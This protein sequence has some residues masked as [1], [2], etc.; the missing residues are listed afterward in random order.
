V[1]VDLHV[2]TWYSPD[3]MM[4]PRRLLKKAVA[5]GLSAVAITDHNRLTEVKGGEIP[6]IPGEEIKTSAGEIIGLF[7]NQEIPAGLDPYEAMD[8]VREQGGIVVI[9]HPF[10]KF[11]K[12][13]ALLLHIRDVPRDVLIEVKNGRYVCRCFEKRAEE[14]ARKRGLPTVGGSD[15]HTYP[16]L[17]RVWT[18]VP[19]FSDSEE[20]F[21]ILRRGETRPAGEPFPWMHATVPALKFLHFV[22]VLPQRP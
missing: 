11:R 3:G 2:H 20:L 12:R 6:I 15:A 17:G 4:E 21:K 18:E 5:L 9:P 1:R 22:G 7:L 13:T 14:F 8:R 10:D 16:E 19:E